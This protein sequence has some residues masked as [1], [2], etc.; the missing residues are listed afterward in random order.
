MKTVFLL[1]GL[2][3]GG[4]EAKQEN[5]PIA[6]YEQRLESLYDAAVQRAEQAEARCKEL[7]GKQ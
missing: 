5:I 6:S 1:V 3:L 4:C 7:E 2:V